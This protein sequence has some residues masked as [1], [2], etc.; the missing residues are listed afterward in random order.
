M[1]VWYS[2]EARGVPTVLQDVEQAGT[3]AARHLAARGIRRFGYVGI[4]RSDACSGRIEGFRAGA[5]LA[6]GEFRRLLAPVTLS[7]RSAIWDRFQASLTQWIA[8]WKTPFGVFA[9]NDMIARYVANAARES[10]LTIPEDVAIVG[11]GNE[12]VAC[13]RPDPTLSSIDYGY[14]RVGHRAAEILDGLMSGGAPPAEP[15]YLPPAELAARASTDSYAVGDPLVA[16]ALRY[17]TDEAHRPIKVSDVVAHVHASHRSLA[18]HFQS[19]RGRTI[20]EELARIRLGRAK[21][22]LVESG[23]PVKEVAAACGYQTSN[24]LCE[25]FRKAEGITPGQYRRKHGPAGRGE[26][27][28]L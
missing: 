8:E 10:G 25:S 18:R 24:R 5:Q 14:Q 2:S 13:L 12:T 17:M 11:S 19:E 9:G 27:D 22:L 26:P 16:R 23:A 4:Q 20:I 1:N 6:G 21:R 7:D 3:M 28:H 15:I